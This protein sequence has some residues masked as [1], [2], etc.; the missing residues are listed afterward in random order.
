MGNM[1]AH[2]RKN[3]IWFSIILSALVL[4]L[5]TVITGGILMLRF[6]RSI[7]T[8]VSIE[9]GEALPGVS[10][11]LESENSSVRVES[12]LDSI[13]TKVPGVYPVE[14]AWGPFHKTTYLTVRDTVPPTGEVQ[15]LLSETGVEHPV[16]DFVV[17]AEDIT[18]VV[19]HF[20]K[21]PDYQTEGV[22]E[23]EIFLE[24]AGGNR[25]YLTAELT[26]YDPAY[27]PKIRGLRNQTVFV[28]ESIAYRPGVTIEDPMDPEA[29]L[30]IDNSKVNLEVPGSYPVV[31]TANDK[32][33]RTGSETVYVKVEELPENYADRQ[34]LDELCTELLSELIT[35]GM[36]DIEKTFAIF[37]WV[38]R[39]VP[40]NGTRTIRDEVAEALE[41]LQGHSGDC[42]THMITCK[43]LLDKAGIENIQIQRYPGPGKHFWLMVHIDGEWYHLDP[44][45]IYMHQHV[46]FLE[47]DGELE[48]FSAAIR[49]N[50][51]A[52]DHSAY[53]ETPLTSPAKAT[54]K[55]GD[56]YLKLEEQ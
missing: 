43:A 41:G 46:G 31:Y 48:M 7:R 15:D 49:P 27:E 5:G 33:G 6:D 21:T 42:F 8:E 16:T 35:D 11:F 29:Q 36:T 25:T 50:Y 9:A 39:N 19:P 13:D 56:Y 20:V 2:N 26:L 18:S 45:P 53:P 22:Q 55:N 30:S 10:A 17:N 52:Y 54:Y 1:K 38:R 4:L 37:R 44:S 28:G 32:Y 12:G 47:T 34:L 51:Y 40:W 24:D 14:L 23:I 3:R